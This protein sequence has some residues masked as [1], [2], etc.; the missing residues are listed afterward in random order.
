MSGNYGETTE[1]HVLGSFALLTGA[2]PITVIASAQR[3]VAYLAL[4]DRQVS[5]THIAGELWPDT[6]ARKAAANLRSA[7]WRVQS[8][9][10]SLI[11]TSTQQ[12]SLAQDAVVDVRLVTAQARSL[13]DGG[14]VAAAVS[15]QRQLAADVLPDWYD[16]W[17]IIEREQFHQ[18]RLH[19]LEVM[20]EQLA[21]AGHYGEA[22]DVGLAAL[23]AEPLRESA[24]RVLIMAHLLAGNRGHALQQFHRCRHLLRQELGLEPSVELVELIR[25]GTSRPQSNTHRSDQ[26]AEHGFRRPRA[27]LPTYS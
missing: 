20:C 10:R 22:V 2:H 18:L 16:D 24:H 15:V 9:C 19:A 13:L 4:N 26:R 14:H 25:H 23:R 1:V 17:V 11:W 21:A 8:A 6:T 27:P 7:L 12:L 5:R 3:L